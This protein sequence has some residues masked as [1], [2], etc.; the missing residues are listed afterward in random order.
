VFASRDMLLLVEPGNTGAPVST[1][2]AGVHH[3]HVT[4]LATGQMKSSQPFVYCFVVASRKHALV[5]VVGLTD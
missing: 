2:Y 5:A 3:L 1:K 4:A